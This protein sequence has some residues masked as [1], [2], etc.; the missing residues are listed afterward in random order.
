MDGSGF[1][2]GNRFHSISK[3]AQHPRTSGQEIRKS[4]TRPPRGSTKPNRLWRRAEEPTVI[5]RGN[6]K[7]EMLN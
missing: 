6:I 4:C 2:G 1:P 5:L 3:I 7:G